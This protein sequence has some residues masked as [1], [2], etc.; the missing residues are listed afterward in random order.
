MTGI[1]QMTRDYALT[2]TGDEWAEGASFAEHAHRNYGACLEVSGDMLAAIRSQ[3]AAADT[4]EADC[5]A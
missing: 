1:D 3:L 4:G 2:T 5:G